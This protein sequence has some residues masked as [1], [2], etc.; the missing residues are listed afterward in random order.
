MA[1]CAN[2]G[3]EIPEEDKT[4]LCEDCKRIIL[5]FIKFMDGSDTP[6]VK[7]L[8][9]NEPNLRIAGVTDSG[10]DYLYRICELKDRKAQIARESKENSSTAAAF[11]T[12][13][14]GSGAGSSG[15]FGKKKI[16]AQSLPPSQ[17]A[18]GDSQDPPSGQGQS[19]VSDSKSQTKPADQKRE[20][21]SKPLAGEPDANAG[22]TSDADRGWEDDSAVGRAL[23]AAKW[24]MILAG[25]AS[26][27]WFA[28][29]IVT[30]TFVGESLA[31]SIDV[32]ALAAALSSY[33][34]A[35]AAETVRKMLDRMGK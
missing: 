23:P 9:S 18:K 17:S 24:I 28:A 1:R 10:M 25:T 6:A 13:A 32:G 3:R 12:A 30:R 19:E 31:D 34:G 29:K 21:K 22:R 33:S 11:G 4:R 2:C 15:G 16:T 14:G 5:P 8:L 20:K 35:Y 26:L 7:R 27:L